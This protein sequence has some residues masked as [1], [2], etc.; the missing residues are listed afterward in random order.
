MILEAESQ[1][2]EEI[3]AARREGARLAGLAEEASR[4]RV[5]KARESYEE[6]ASS[7]ESQ[8]VAEA[9]ERAAEMSRNSDARIAAMRARAATR[10]EQAT[11]ALVAAI[12]ATGDANEG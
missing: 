4:E 11:P 12:L 6:T 8:I 1:A 3:D 9:K 5:R 7:F 10:G 2:R